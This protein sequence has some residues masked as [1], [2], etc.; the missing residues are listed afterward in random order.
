MSPPFLI[1]E[2]AARSGFTAS[3]LRYYEQ[4]G[5]LH[6]TQRSAGG[7]RLYDEPAL[8]RLR[9]IDRAKQL[10][11]PL[12]EI[13]DLVA[14]WDTG[15]CGHV[16]DRLRE[17]IAAK[18]GEVEARIEQ[19]RAFAIQL[20][21]ARRT[22]GT[23]TPDSRCGDDC[24]CADPDSAHVVNPPGV[25]LLELTPR[26]ELL[27]F[28][29]STQPETQPQT[30]STRPSPVSI[31][32]RPPVPVACTLKPAEQPARASAWAQLLDRVQERTVID[33]GL[34]LRFPVDSALAGQLAELAV[35]EQE[36]CSFLTFSLHSGTELL[37]D[38]LAPDDAAAVIADLFG[39]QP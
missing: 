14:V 25:T 7:Y 24:G 37:L 34:R 17:H 32:S 33:G 18:K 31:A 13:R 15:P 23:L 16:Q 29:I 11:L 22:L 8:A 35:Q 4:V 26:G 28:P 12:K 1:S 10:G 38:V 20:D 36:C 6:A 21:Q 9:F 5:L 2:L 3:T 30:I 19:L 27:A 39:T